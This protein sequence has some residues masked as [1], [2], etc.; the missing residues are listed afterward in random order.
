MLQRIPWYLMCPAKTITLYNSA[1]TKYKDM[2]L[3]AY[4]IQLDQPKQT[5]TAK[6]AKD[7]AGVIIGRPKMVQ[8]DNT[9]TSDQIVYDLKTQKGIT[10]NTFTQSGEIYIQGQKVKK[11]SPTEFYAFKGQFTTCNLDT[12]HFAFVT[13]KMK[14]INQKMAI[15]GPIHPEFEGVPVPIY[16]PF[17]YFPISSG[18]HSGFLPPVFTASPDFGLGLEGLGYYKVLSDNFDVTFRA[19]VYSYGGWRF[20]LTPEYRVRY[21]YNG[22]LTF[23]MQNTKQLDPT[24]KEEFASSK[25][26][27]L[28]WSHAM[29]S[30]ARP[31]T[32]FSA[33]VNVSSSKFNQQVY[34]NPTINYQNSQSSSITYSKTWN[35]KYNLTVSANHNQNNLNRL[36]TLNIPN[37]AFTA[38]TVYPFQKKEFVGAPKWYEKLGIGLSSNVTGQ[39]SF[40]DSLFSFHHLL[41]TFQWGAQHS[42]PISLALPSMF[43]GALQVAPGISLQQKW[44]SQ[45]TTQV[46]N[47]SKQQLDTTIQKGFFTAEDVAFSLNLSTA[48]FGTFNKFG[49]K[50]SVLGLRHVIRPTIGITYKPDLAKNYYYRSRY[51]AAGDSATHSHFEGS[52]YGTFSPG[53]FG[54]I[55]FGFDNNLEM[56]V[57]SK[58]DTSE[59]G[60]KKIKLIDGFGFTGSYNYLA[61]SFKLSPISFYLRSTLFG[62]FN[63]T[64]G[65]TL[66]PY[67]A[68]SLGK[69]HNTLAW[70]DGK[71][72]S[73][74]RITTGSLAISTSFKSKPKDA[75]KADEQKKA[76]DNLTPDYT[77]KKSR[78]NC[79][80]SGI[81]RPSLLILILNGL[82]TYP[83][84]SVFPSSYG[85]I[86]AVTIPCL[87]QP[88]AGMAI[89]T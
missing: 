87:I 22:R 58:S 40:Y 16:L 88:L 65:I 86:T 79:N 30:K 39:G 2:N 3:E 84:P 80:T 10:T 54:G 72:F 70:Q 44:Y 53:R 6:Y 23:T 20:D 36:Y 13:K 7:T 25:T 17:G 5:V 29:D 1:N 74:G 61:D 64:G 14:L 34:N 81:I 56:K 27:K 47:N 37:V 9:M 62:S 28:L 41:D 45:K 50:S 55:S 73:L 75:K 57:R 19:N 15:S 11:I 49:K 4:Q 77:P 33:S 68:D 35:G 83:I 78:R 46:W 59:S 85:P 66:D 76:Q 43:G 82:S 18:R 8:A 48:I 21:R 32:N 42:I 69:R 60:I 38:I 52:P 51:D 26:F 71:G 12:P 67:I 31:G 24:G 63:I 89:L